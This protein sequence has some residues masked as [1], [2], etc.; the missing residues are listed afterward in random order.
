MAETETR[1]AS[2]RDAPQFRV[3]ASA[4]APSA[5]YFFGVGMRRGRRLAGAPS[6]IPKVQ[7]A[8]TFF[9]C[10]FALMNHAARFLAQFLRH[11]V[12]HRAGFRIII[13]RNHA[14]TAHAHLHAAG[15]D[16]RRSR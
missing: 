15:I 5:S 12:G 13:R 2:L 11:L 16:L 10:D 14:E 7:C 1:G 3:L 8:S 6:S 4:S 9:P